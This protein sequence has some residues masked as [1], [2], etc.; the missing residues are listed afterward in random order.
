MVA[1]TVPE[2]QNQLKSLMTTILSI[3]TVETK[4]VVLRGGQPPFDYRLK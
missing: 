1:N 2:M 4:E 3:D